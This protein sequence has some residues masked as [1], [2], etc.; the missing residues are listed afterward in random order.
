MIE[1][2]PNT[3]KH[4]YYKYIIIFIVLSI[5][6]IGIIFYK[7]YNKTISPIKKESINYNPA[8]IDQQKN[9]TVIKKGSIDN[10]NNKNSTTSD[11]PSSPIIQSD[12]R[13]LITLD[14]SSLNQ[15]DTLFQVRIDIGTVTNSGN[16][17][18]TLKKDSTKI[19]KSAAVYPLAKNSTCQGF[20][21][22]MSELSVGIWQLNVTFNNTSLTGSI[23]KEIT[24]K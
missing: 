21:I 4:K 9:G 1:R 14:I 12:G 11:S 2:K 7:N 20:D 16:C 23:S 22:P 24:I 17:E 3:I 19:T 5:T 10:Q 15:T 18:L 13:G 6:A 8:T